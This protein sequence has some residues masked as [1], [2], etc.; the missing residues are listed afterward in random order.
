MHHKGTAWW[1]MIERI[2]VGDVCQITGEQFKESFYAK[3]FSAS[4]RDAKRQEFLNLEQG[5]RTVE[6]YGVD[7][8]ML[9]RF[10]SE[11][12]AN[13]IAR[14]DKFVREECEI[15]WEAPF[16]KLLKRSHYVPP[17][18]STIWVVYLGLELVSSGKVFAT[19]K[20]EVE[21]AGTVVAVYTPYGESMLSKEKIKVCQIEI[22]NHVIDVILL[23]LNMHDFDVILDMDWLDANHASI[24][25]SRR[26]VVFNPST[27]TSFKF[28]GRD[29]VSLSLKPMVRDYPDTF[30]EELPGLSPHREI[31]FA[32]EL[33]P[34][35]VPISKA[36]YRLTST[37]LKVLKV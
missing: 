7:F 21:K 31:N 23:V 25:Y 14:V 26:E 2:L 24:D 16:G 8:D 36:L 6:H 13:E 27:R 19:N 32:I 4:L 20:F 11:M 1:E 34:D 5:D 12:I 35:T 18:G 28:K 10:A 30:P 22:T 33:E 9:S 3:F 17:V 37:E 29:Y 15:M